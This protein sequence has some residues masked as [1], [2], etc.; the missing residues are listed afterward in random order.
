MAW[1]DP[2]RRRS[3]IACSGLLLIVFVVLHLVGVG[4]APLAPNRFEAYATALLS[5]GGCPW[6]R[7]CWR[8]WPG[9]MGG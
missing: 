3:L 7:G 1:L 5:G 2:P 6:L 4:L 8:R 9:F